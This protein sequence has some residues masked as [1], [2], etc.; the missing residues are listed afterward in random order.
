[1]KCERAEQIIMMEHADFPTSLR[2]FIQI[3]CVKK[4]VPNRCMDYVQYVER[5]RVVFRL[6]GGG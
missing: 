2:V 6:M 3:K 4:E 1:M 5:E